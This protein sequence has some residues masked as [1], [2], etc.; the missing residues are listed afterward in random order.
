MTTTVEHGEVL[1]EPTDESLRRARLWAYLRWLEAERGLTFSDRTALWRWSIEDQEGFWS[2]IWEYFDVPAEVH[3]ERMIT[4]EGAMPGVQWFPGALLNYAEQVF[5]F[6][7]DDRVTVHGYSQ[8]RAPV[9]LTLGDLRDQVGR[10][11]AVLSDLGVG[12]GDRVVAYVPNSPEAVVGFLAA[13]ALGATWAS[14][15]IEF[16]SRS[17]LERFGQV[18]PMVL[19]TVGGYGYGTKKIDK[20]GDIADVIA[21]LPTLKHVIDLEYGDFRTGVE[22]AVLWNAALKEAGSQVLEFEQ[23]AADH[24]LFVLFSS[25]TTGLPKAIVHGHGGVLLEHLKINTLSWDLGPGDV[26]LWYSTTAWMMWNTLVSSLLVGASIVCVDGHPMYP[27]ADWQWRIAEETGATVMGAAPGFIM[28]SRRGRLRPGHDLDLRV[29]VFASAGAPLPP[30]GYAWVYEQLP[31]VLLIV[32]SG[33]TDVCSAIVQGDP[34]TTV[35]AGEISGPA[36]GVAAF[37]FDKAGR[38]VVGELG[39]LVITRPL[40]SMPVSFWGD[41]D[42]TRLREAYFDAFPGV[43]RHGDWII[44]DRRGHCHVTGRSDATLNRGGVRLGTAEFYRVTEEISGV[45][46][47]LVV[48]LEEGGGNGELLL[49]VQTG[50]GRDLDEHLR[51]SIVRALRTQLSPRHAP[52]TIEQVPVIPYNRTGKKLEVPVKKILQ[53][54]PLE[55]VASRDALADP[56]AL[57]AIV[58]LMRRRAER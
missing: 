27:D 23:V 53:G 56:T 54:R 58:E 2:S 32:G 1:W 37:A 3:P 43:W 8:T 14:C 5:R 46:D 29:R 33:G 30:E 11:R 12:R 24:P 4:G 47:S 48:H 18:E 36:F 55:E 9:G 51:G 34:W 7:D 26:F 15:A 16:G 6:N 10:A 35:R 40:P 20:A 42:G 22:G 28:A 50:P 52:D 39:E 44:F 31:G 21:G 38:K 57:D 41:P 19:I 17:V 45:V 25:G 13:A 49:L